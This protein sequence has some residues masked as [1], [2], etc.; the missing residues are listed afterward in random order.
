MRD[1]ITRD[2]SRHMSNAHPDQRPRLCGPRLLVAGM[3]V[4]SLYVTCAPEA[5]AERSDYVGAQTCRV[6]HESAYQVWR[7][8]A[9]ARADTSLGAAP[10][11]ACLTC[12]TT[13]DT[14]AVARILPR[15]NVN[16]A[17]VRGPATP[18]QISC[19]IGH[20]PPDWG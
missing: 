3:L 19:A 18:R 20:W 1:R 7:K 12:H 15:C 10:A 9:H 17:T 8:S 5:R 4:A 13:G 6:C 2:R 14:P 16:R 11:P